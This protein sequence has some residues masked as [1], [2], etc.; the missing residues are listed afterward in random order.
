M[1]AQAEER[2]GR[3]KRL[4][5]V[6]PAGTYAFG[7]PPSKLHTVALLQT[8]IA[9]LGLELPVTGCAHREPAHPI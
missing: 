2:A 8:T 9:P 7:D 1:H 5:N 6:H 4:A 3:Q